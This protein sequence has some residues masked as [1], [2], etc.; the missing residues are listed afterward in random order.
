ME[1]YAPEVLDSFRLLADTGC[2]DFLTETY[3]HSLASLMPGN[4]FEMQADKHRK[5]ILRHFGIRSKVF[6]NTELIYSDAT[7]K[8]I[9]E[10]PITPDKLI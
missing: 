9:R 5:K 7:G 10:L 8:R 6:R 1:A 4:E 2:V 3:Y